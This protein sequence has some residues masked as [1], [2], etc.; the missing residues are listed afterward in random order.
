MRS[1]LFGVAWVIGLPV[2][3]MGAE[4]THKEVFEQ[5]ILPIFKS[6][7]PSSCVQCHL[8]GVDLKDY[9][10]PDTE[11]TFRSLR[12]QG[13]IDLVNPEKSKIIK[14]IDM[15]DTRASDGGPAAVHAKNRKAEREAFIAWIAACATDPKLK[16]LP[17]LEEPPPAKPP[18]PV[19][20]IRHA[21]K[22]RVLE[23]FEANVWAWRFRCMNCHTEG[24]P[25]NDKLRK[26]HGERVA[27]VKKDGSLATLDYLISSKLIDLEKPEKSLL[28]TKPLGEK[29]EGGTKFVIGDDAYKGFRSWIEDVVAIKG[30]KYP[31]AKE[32]P[33]SEPIERFGTDLWLKLTDTPA[34]WADQFLQVRVFAWDAKRKEWEDKPIA[35]SDRIVFGKGKL[36]QH[37]LTLLAE[38]DSERAKAWRTGKPSLPEGKYMVK[39]YVDSEGKLGKDWKTLLTEKEYV[40]QTALNT[41]WREGYNAMTN[42][43]AKLVRK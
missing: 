8:S 43:D 15:K 36:W 38:K 12:D 40:G 42:V 5:R 20:V 22:D 29:H 37:N 23:S 18:L 1:I 24:T 34:V 39:I 17:R 16:Q 13:L 27:W 19:E 4:P 7:N 28:L 6:P 31:S 21:R 11:K 41:A 14:L 32:L 3:A 35:V 26:Q 10:L 30:N 25:Q 33:K 2:V 9:I